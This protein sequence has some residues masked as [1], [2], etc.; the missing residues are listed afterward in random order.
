MCFAYIRIVLLYRKTQQRL[1]S[2]GADNTRGGL[3][4][5]AFEKSV[6]PNKGSNENLPTGGSMRNSA[7]DSE[8]GSVQKKD[9]GPAKKMSSETKLLIKAVVLAG[10]FALNW[11]PYL[12]LYDTRSDRSILLNVATGQTSS[13]EFDAFCNLL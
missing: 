4:S 13:S 3:G 7:A 11:S 9:K 2:T 8:S 6:G 1:H 5:H 10:T 12:L